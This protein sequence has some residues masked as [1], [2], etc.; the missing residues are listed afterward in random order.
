MTTLISIFNRL[1]CAFSVKKNEK[2]L[3]MKEEEDGEVF[4]AA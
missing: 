1:G 2:A 4:F 3:L